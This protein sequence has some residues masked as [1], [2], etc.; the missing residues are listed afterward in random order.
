MANEGV[1]IS[2]LVEKTTL[3]GTEYLPVQDGEDN[4]KMKTDLFQKKL[5]SGT[6]IK[7]FNDES[8]LGSGNISI[9]ATLDKS[10]NN[11]IRNSAVAI[12]IEEITTDTDAKFTE[13]DSGVC[14]KVKS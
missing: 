6:D 3:S 5:V 9:D 4:K 2:E 1:K 10:S 12:K 14:K 8:L 13:L 11:A 7:T